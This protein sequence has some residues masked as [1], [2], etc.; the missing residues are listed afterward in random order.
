MEKNL[1]VYLVRYYDNIKDAEDCII[2]TVDENIR[3]I[4]PTIAEQIFNHIYLPDRYQGE[5]NIITMDKVY[6]AA[7]SKIEKYKFLNITGE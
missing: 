7:E 6:S 4:N 3:D 1:N 5:I 2:I